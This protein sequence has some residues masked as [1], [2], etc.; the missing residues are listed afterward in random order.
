MMA[1]PT[2]PAR[3]MEKLE[4]AQHLTALLGATVAL[5][6]RAPGERTL[7]EVLARQEPRLR[8]LVALLG[9]IRRDVGA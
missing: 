8:D 6:R 3:V 1:P 2:Q 7:E 9:D 5:I 4:R